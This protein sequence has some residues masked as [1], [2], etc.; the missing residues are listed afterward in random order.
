MTLSN[1][2][3]L[4]LAEQYG[5]PL[6]VYDADRIEHQVKRLRESFSWPQTRLLYAMKANFNVGILRFLRSLQV[7]IDAVSIGDVLMAQAA[8]YNAGEILCTVNNIDQNEMRS[9]HELGVLLNIDSLSGLA[10]LG[11]L[12]PGSEVCVRF[13][14]DVVAGSH[15][16]IQTGG[17]KTKFGVPLADVAEVQKVVKQ[18]QL[19]IVGI[20]WHT[21][22]GIY[23][24]Q[25]VLESLDNVL[26]RVDSATFPHL[27]FVD[28]GGGLGVR[29]HQ[30]DPELDVAALGKEVSA[31]F[32]QFCLSYGKPL[33]L[34][35]EPGKFLVAEAGY[36]LA[37][38]TTLKN[39]YGRCIV[40]TNSGF[41]QL[42]RPVL[43]DAYHHIRNI[44]NAGAAA[45]SYDIYG[46]ICESGDC[47]GR[48]RMLP[49]VREG[50]ILAI[51][52]AGAYGYS[53]ASTYNL[54]PLPAEVLLRSGARIH[55]GR[56]QTPQKL[57][58]AL[59][60]MSETIEPIS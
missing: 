46:N 29:Y 56:R 19:R 39:S 6:Y 38:V 52:N 21:G 53:M 12:A 18:H 16:H 47:F 26:S 3:L 25:A 59:L 45:H 27:R 58:N 42:I 41:A 1:A 10:R 50:D 55:V 49:E 43:Y 60:A 34:W 57:V 33:E 40:G 36:L 11:A 14:P 9:T 7:G 35:V 51:E 28:I 44:S 23:E 20:H 15:R 24:S 2:E 31:R 32:K 17:A 37:S 13:N 4:Q 22:S 8:G 5:T 48:E 54:R 30:E